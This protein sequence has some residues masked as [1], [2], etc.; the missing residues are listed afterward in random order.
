MKFQQSDETVKET[1]IIYQWGPSEVM[2]YTK[3]SVLLNNSSELIFYAN[4]KTTLHSHIRVH[5]VFSGSTSSLSAEGH[6][7]M[8]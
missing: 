7:L 3:I 4:L 1:L 2:P 6:E 8:W 5:N